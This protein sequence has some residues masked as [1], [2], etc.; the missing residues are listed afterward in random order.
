MEL[1]LPAPPF[2][3][4]DLEK[5]PTISRPVSFFSYKMWYTVVVRA[6]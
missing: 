2:T 1:C 6:K 3:G 4:S 5:L